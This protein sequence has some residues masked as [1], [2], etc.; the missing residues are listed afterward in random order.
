M[1][2]WSQSVALAKESWRVVRT[3]REILLFPLLGGVG[4]VLV[5]ILFMV[6]LGLT[7]LPSALQRGDDRAIVPALVVLWLFLFCQTLV[8]LYAQTALIGAALIR[9]RGGDPTVSDGLAVASSRLGAI[10]GFAAISATVGLILQ[11]LGA[12]A[13]GKGQERGGG[14]AAVLGSIV[15]A[16]VGAAWSVATYFVVPVMIVEQLGPTAALRR[17]AAII[18]RAW[19]ESAIVNVGMG[20]VF[21]LI[22]VGVAV[23]GGGVAYALFN[24]RVLAGGLAI[25]ALTVLALCIVALVQG[26][27]KGVFVAALYRYAVDGEVSPAYFEED[28]LRRAFAPVGAP[29]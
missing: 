14:A 7:D 8:V 10:V 12:L 21:G 1:S 27:L 29:A 28:L 17:S 5:G 25:A 20:L 3:D 2:K 11:V 26:A 4:M 24:A 22:Y 18:R 23:V 13:R 6:P 15:V 9:L 19:G 16:L